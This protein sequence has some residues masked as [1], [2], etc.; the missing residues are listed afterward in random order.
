MAPTTGKPTALVEPVAAAALSLAALASEPVAAA[1]LAGPVAGAAA[2]AE[3][4]AAT[5]EPAGAE[6]LLALLV[7]FAL[8]SVP[9]PTGP[10]CG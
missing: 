1:V 3:S 9:S 10:G 2:L 5:S 8:A 7:A 4:V 6:P